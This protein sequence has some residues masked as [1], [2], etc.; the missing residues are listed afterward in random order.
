MRKGLLQVQWKRVMANF[1]VWRPTTARESRPRIGNT[2]YFPTMSN[3]AV[4]AGASPL[5]PNWAME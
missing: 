1:F 2:V 5:D 4:V 3:A